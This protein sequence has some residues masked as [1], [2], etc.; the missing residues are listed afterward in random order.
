MRK[1]I[2]DKQ[3]FL[4]AVKALRGHLAARPLTKAECADKIEALVAQSQAAEARA[5]RAQQP[6]YE[7]GEVVFAHH[8]EVMWAKHVA[9]QAGLEASAYRQIADSPLHAYHQTTAHLANRVSFYAAR[10]GVR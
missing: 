10:A 2:S 5:E 4:S 7:N 1:P 8:E 9:F 3:M 6:V